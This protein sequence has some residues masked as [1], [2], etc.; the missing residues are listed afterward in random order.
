MSGRS[1]K[2]S[3]TGGTAVHIFRR[4]QPPGA[5]AVLVADGQNALLEGHRRLVDGRHRARS[6][7]RPTLEGQR[8][9]MNP[10]ALGPGS[11]VLNDY[12]LMMAQMVYDGQ[13]AAAPEPARLHPH[14]LRI[15]WPAALRRGIVVGRYLRHLDR[16]GQ[17]DSRRPGFLHERCSL[18]DDGRGR[19]FRAAA[20]LLTPSDPAATG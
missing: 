12:A 15:R 10:T 14:A 9:Y 2:K 11:A 8:E 4:V 18:L 19:F 6:D 17:A 13:R 5:A 3:S 16:H 1:R 7:A 20:I